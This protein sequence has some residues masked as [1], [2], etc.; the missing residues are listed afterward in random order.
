MN[1]KVGNKHAISAKVNKNKKNAFDNFCFYLFMRCVKYLL[2]T[3]L[4][5]ALLKL[6]FAIF[7]QIFI[8]KC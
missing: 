8:T 3:A 5:I 6:V 1:S 2:K 7:Y 4:S